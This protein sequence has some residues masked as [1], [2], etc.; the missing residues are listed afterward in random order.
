M[1]RQLT[2]RQ[3][4]NA[5]E[6]TQHL[7][8]SLYAEANSSDN[9][10]RIREDV[11][12]SE[13]WCSL[14]EEAAQLLENP[15]RAPLFTEF[16]LFGDTGDRAI[17]QS[18]RDQ[19]YAGIHA[20]SMLAMTEDK[21]EW[22]TGLENAIWNVCNEYTWVLPAHVGLYRNDYPNGIWDQPAP[23]R[24]TV[25]LLSA[26]T[27]FTL[28][29]TVHLLGDRLHPWV[30]HRVN[31]EIDRRIFQVYFHDATPQNWELKTN[32][33]PAV[34]SASIG[35]TA[36]YMIDDSEKL[37]GMLWRVIGVLRN[38][39][40]GF[41]EQGATPEGPAYWQYGFSH[42]VYFA[43]LLKERTDGRISLLTDEK[44]EPISKFPQFCM[45]T[46]GKVVNFSDSADEVTLNS[47]LI[48]RLQHYVPSLQLPIE[49]YRMSP[50]PGNWLD[51]TRQMLWSPSMELLISENDEERLQEKVFTGNQWVI[52]KVRDSRGRIIAFAAKGGHNEEPHNHN[53]LGHFILHVDGQNVLADIGLGRYT[54]Q[55]FQPRFRYEMINAG[56][57]G[58][59]VPIVDG[60]RQGFG[61]S[62]RSEILYSQ[63]S[64]DNVQ[65]VMDLTKAYDCGSLEC[66]TREFVWERPLHKIPQL[67]ITDRA[68]F[69]NTPLTF[70][71]V[72]ISSVRPQV[73]SSGRLQMNTV[74]LLYNP[75]KWEIEIEHIWVDSHYKTG[76]PFYRIVLN[77]TQLEREMI[78]EFRFEMSERSECK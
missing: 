46:G 2:F 64:E 47:G 5:L 27:A 43:E 58:H 53:D 44:V 57:H 34:C 38:Y 60:C 15:I 23:P 26:M 31:E 52:S 76:T 32:N 35:A 30:V 72:F 59:S 18:K 51:S 3:L 8:R 62:Y 11:N 71:E 68:T 12:Y 49:E 50:V 54:K 61:T 4:K 42:F 73:T 65:V 75:E 24:E 33:W 74:T 36:I 21:L 45:L 48:H 66:L 10:R 6:E 25:D 19:L 67:V 28:A 9:W 7:P 55:Y 14:E 37:A 56:S 63:I 16:T 70:Q 13:F 29:E 17:Y 69:S 39:L 1:L 20:F 78:F 40:S 22:K 41:D 77:R